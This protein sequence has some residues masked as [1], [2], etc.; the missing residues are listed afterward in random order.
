[1][2][3]PNQMATPPERLP[4]TGATVSYS[5][6]VFNSWT[7]TGAATDPA[8]SGLA[9]TITGS[10]TVTTTGAAAILVSADANPG[11]F[12]N[13]N[14]NKGVLIKL[15]VNGVASNDVTLGVVD[16]LPSPGTEG[17]VADAFYRDANGDGIIQINESRTFGAPRVMD[18][19]ALTLWVPEPASMLAL[20]TGLV[21]LLAARRRNK[22]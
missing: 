18:N 17:L 22:K 3:Q 9:G 5:I 10:T 11:I 20:G 16:R 19:L 8:F 4:L 13:T 2:V 7:V 12:L 6:D 21:G 1:M 15:L 14:P